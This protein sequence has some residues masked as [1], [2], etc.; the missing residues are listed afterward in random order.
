M[1]YVF[2]ISVLGRW[3]WVDPWNLLYSQPS[4]G[5]NERSC[6]QVWQL[7]RSSH[8]LASV[9]VHTRTCMDAPLQPNGVLQ[10]LGERLYIFITLFPSVFGSLLS[11]C[12][13]NYF[14][15]FIFKL[16]FLFY[17]ILGFLYMDVVACKC[18]NLITS[19]F[20]NVFILCVHV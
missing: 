2:V 11:H 5:Q 4:T 20:S 19:S 18:D 17:K 13:W 3:R 16:S 12:K 6:L 7:L 15:S 1:W 14:I 10:Y 8:H 9:Y